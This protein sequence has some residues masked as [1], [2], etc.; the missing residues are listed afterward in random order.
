MRFVSY[1]I[2]N[3]H[4]SDYIY[5]IIKILLARKKSPRTVPYTLYIPSFLLC[6]F[7]DENIFIYDIFIGMTLI[8]LENVLLS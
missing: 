1:N 7:G 8:N 6:A 3:T 2:S 5:E 4:T